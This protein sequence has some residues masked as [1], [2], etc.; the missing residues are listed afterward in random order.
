[1]V[2]L[3]ENENVMGSDRAGLRERLL[4]GAEDSTRGI[5]RNLQLIEEVSGVHAEVKGLKIREIDTQAK[6]INALR[7]RLEKIYEAAGVSEDD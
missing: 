6:R 5:L 1:L 3:G 2:R 7:E 4:Q